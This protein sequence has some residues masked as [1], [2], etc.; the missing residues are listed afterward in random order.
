MLMRTNLFYQYVGSPL[1]KQNVAQSQRFLEEYNI[2]NDFRKHIF[3]TNPGTR[4][5]H[6]RRDG[7]NLRRAEQH[8]WRLFR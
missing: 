4:E 6:P 2:R 7:S 3:G 1:Y 8:S 5:Y